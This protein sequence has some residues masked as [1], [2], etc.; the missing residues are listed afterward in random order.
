MTLWLGSLLPL[1]RKAL[2]KKDCYAAQREQA[3]SPQ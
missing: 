1:E 3:P 2:T